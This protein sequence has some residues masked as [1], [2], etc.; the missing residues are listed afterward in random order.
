LRYS[1]PEMQPLQAATGFK[2]F[3]QPQQ[4]GLITISINPT[5]FW[6]LSAVRGKTANPPDA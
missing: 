6:L 2:G 1:T 3:K 5:M 4:R